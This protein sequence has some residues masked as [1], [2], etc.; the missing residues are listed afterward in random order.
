VK[1]KF[2]ANRGLKNGALEEYYCMKLK[3]IAN[4]GLQNGAMHSNELFHRA[5]FTL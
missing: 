3:F 2:I 5:F 1:L 4:L